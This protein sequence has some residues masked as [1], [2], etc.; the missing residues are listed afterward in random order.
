MLRASCPP[1]L[2]ISKRGWYR[3]RQL[4]RSSRR[5]SPPPA[6][7]SPVIRDANS[8]DLDAMARLD[9]A[10]EGDGS[11]GWSLGIWKET[12]ASSSSVVLVALDN[13]TLVGFI[14]SLMVADELQVENLAVARERRG[15]RIG[16]QLMSKLIEK[17]AEQNPV[18]CLL[19]VR[20]G[21]PAVYFYQRIGFEITGRR[22]RFYPDG[23][24]ALLMSM[25]LTSVT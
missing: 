6:Q 19:E 4:L 13:D 23:C 12:L 14:S 16:Q 7:C 24:A 11:A 25:R 3:P 17:S 5:V 20:E 2:V 18:V 8:D 9:E 10:S 15:R 1:C 22:A 21:S